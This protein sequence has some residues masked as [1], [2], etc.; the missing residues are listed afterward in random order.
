MFGKGYL[1]KLKHKED[2]E[3]A[4]EELERDLKAMREEE[5][6]KDEEVEPVNEAY[7]VNEVGSIAATLDLLKLCNN[8]IYEKVQR[9]EPISNDELPDYVY[10]D[11]CREIGERM[12]KQ[13]DIQYRF[14]AVRDN[15]IFV[16][17]KK[18]R[19]KHLL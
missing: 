13:C 5:C 19:D 3:E 6:G 9:I 15:V 2:E 1:N 8:D 7:P 12:I 16:A 11:L 18:P 10:K 4:Y 17:V 14:D